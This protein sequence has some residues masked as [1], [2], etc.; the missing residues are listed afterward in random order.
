MMLSVCIACSLSARAADPFAALVRTTDPLTAAEEQ[1]TFKLPPGF[2]IQL[3]AGEP[4]IYKP[5]NMAFAARGASR[6]WP[7]WLYLAYGRA[8]LLLGGGQCMRRER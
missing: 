7:E 3:V 2:E 1:K 8:G 4:D 5:L 6:L